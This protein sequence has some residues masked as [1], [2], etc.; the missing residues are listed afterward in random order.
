MYRAII[1]DLRRWKDKSNRKPLI[2]QGARRVGKTTLIR[3]F[4]DMNY[5]E[6]VYINLKNN[7]RMS[8]L[9]SGDLNVERLI[10]GIE[11]YYGFKII[12]EKTLIFFDEVQTVPRVLLSLKN[13][14]HDA[15]EYNIICDKVQYLSQKEKGSK[16]R[17]VPAL[18]VE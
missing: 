11:L 2:I 5:R 8:E 1:E 18:Q 4:G 17:H 16:N 10:M 6:T 14:H 7:R 12:P 9:F 15:P 3:D 13:F